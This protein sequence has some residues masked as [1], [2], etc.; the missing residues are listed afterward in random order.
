MWE[1]NGVSHLANIAKIYNLPLLLHGNQW[2]M[3]KSV[4][5]S[6]DLGKF[7]TYRPKEAFKVNGKSG[8][9][10][11]SLRLF[12]NQ[13]WECAFEFL[14]FMITRVLYYLPERVGTSGSGFSF[15]NSPIVT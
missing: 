12:G 7:L 2:V 1:L 13:N 15:C 8:Y 10:E 9:P 4:N 5:A 3:E 14:V 11:V 6:S